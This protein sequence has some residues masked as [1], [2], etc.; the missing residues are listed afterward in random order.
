[1]KGPGLSVAGLLPAGT[2]TGLR[3]VV[4]INGDNGLVYKV[5]DAQNIPFV[6]FEGTYNWCFVQLDGNDQCIS[7][8]AGFR[9]DRRQ[10]QAQAED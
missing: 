2:K 6:G 3:Q 8:I 4:V 10:C 5:I 1:M 9:E 7:N